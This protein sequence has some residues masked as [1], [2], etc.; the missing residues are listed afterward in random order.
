M[1]IRQFVHLNWSGNL[2]VERS[3]EILL[4]FVDYF[5]FF[6]L[7]SLSFFL[8]AVCSLLLAI[9]LS[10]MHV[11]HDSRDKKR[12]EKKN[13]KKLSIFLSQQN[14]YSISRL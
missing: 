11:S 14:F 3:N 4:L 10:D 2:F 1:D 6:L 13:N 7:F 9:L 12:N 5:F 8:M